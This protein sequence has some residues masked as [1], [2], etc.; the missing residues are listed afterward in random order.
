[1]VFNASVIGLD[2]FSGFDFST[3]LY[4]NYQCK[5]EC[6]LLPAFLPSRFINLETGFLPFGKTRTFFRS[7]VSATVNTDTSSTTNQK[8]VRVIISS[9]ENR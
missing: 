4:P 9:V 2:D 1:M 8:F 5:M 6:N 7:A 3:P